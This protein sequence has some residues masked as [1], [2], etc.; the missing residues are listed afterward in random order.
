MG[1]LYQDAWIGKFHFH[2]F[3]PRFD[4]EK[5]P[6]FLFIQFGKCLP[7]IFLKKDNLMI[8]F[9]FDLLSETMATSKSLFTH[10]NFDKPFK[11][12][13]KSNNQKTTPIE[14][15]DPPNDTPGA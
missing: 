12:V 15:T 9:R 10:V 6:W 7:S 8:W 14:T 5:R 3:F 4:H 11:Y 1:P 13:Q 2:L